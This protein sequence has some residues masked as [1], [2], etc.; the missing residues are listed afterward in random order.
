MLFHLFSCYFIPYHV[1]IS[2]SLEKIV[3]TEQSLKFYNVP[4][5]R[6]GEDFDFL[7]NLYKYY[8]SS[9]KWIYQ[10]GGVEVSLKF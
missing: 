7:Q 9:V 2:T 8:N 1:Y 4:T 3:K 6:T 5:A 10:A